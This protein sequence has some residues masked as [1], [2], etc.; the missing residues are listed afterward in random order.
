MCEPINIE[1][2]KV[3]AI[4]GDFQCFLLQESKAFGSLGEGWILKHRP[5]TVAVCGFYLF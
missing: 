4:R 5:V 3:S 2:L 1:Q